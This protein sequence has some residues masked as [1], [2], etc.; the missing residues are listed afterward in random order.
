MAEPQRTGYPNS[1]LY[2]RHKAFTVFG[3]GNEGR[4]ALY[5]RFVLTA[6]RLWHWRTAHGDWR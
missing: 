3:I 1:K 2:G 6:R 4:M 5:I